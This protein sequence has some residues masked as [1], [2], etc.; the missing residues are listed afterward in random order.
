MT[1]HR[2]QVTPVTQQHIDAHPIADCGASSPVAASTPAQQDGADAIAHAV[3]AEVLHHIDTMYPAMWGAV[4]K[5]ART[6]IR[7]VILTQS[8][9]YIAKVDKLNA[10]GAARFDYIEDHGSTRGGGNGFTI[11]CFVP[12]DHEDMGCGIDA[13]IAVGAQS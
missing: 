6:S 1:P 7:N 2:D 13:A 8:A 4:A 9:R 5:T 10:Q 12:A 3:A 11:T